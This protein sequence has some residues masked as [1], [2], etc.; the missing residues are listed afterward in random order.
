MIRREKV[1]NNTSSRGIGFFGLLTITFIVLKITKYIDWS[2]WW[3]LAPLW[4]SL[5]IT[6]VIIT[7]ITVL[8][9]RKQK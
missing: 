2:W 5:I 6:I 9:I 8:A 3:V 1:D 7:T 4:M